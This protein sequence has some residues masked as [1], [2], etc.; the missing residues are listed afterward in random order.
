LLKAETAAE[1]GKLGA[2][3]IT[4]QSIAIGGVPGVETSYQ[5]SSAS[6]GTLYASQLEVLPKPDKAC[7]VTVTTA[8]G[9]SDGA[10][11]STAAAT[12]QFP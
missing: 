1:F 3:H 12:A 9:T 10:I 7:F 5:L 11:L 4:Q 8:G 2:T 6:M